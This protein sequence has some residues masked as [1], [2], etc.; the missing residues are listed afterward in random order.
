MHREGK[1]SHLVMSCIQEA[2]KGKPMQGAQPM[3]LKAPDLGCRRLGDELRINCPQVDAAEMPERLF[4]SPYRVT[5]LIDNK[6][7]LT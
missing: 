6:V 7:W 4:G 2:G 5:I 3:Q 1:T